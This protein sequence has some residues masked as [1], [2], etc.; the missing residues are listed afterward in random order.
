MFEDEGHM[1]QACPTHGVYPPFTESVC[2]ADNQ[3]RLSGWGT[4]GQSFDTGVV[5]ENV[6]RLDS[7][8]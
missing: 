1:A 3:S 2:V 8:T 5:E 6:S 7:I 4:N